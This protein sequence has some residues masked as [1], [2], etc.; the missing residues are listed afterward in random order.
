LR[1]KAEGIDL[2]R[3]ENDR[4]REQ[5]TERQADTQTDE[6][7]VRQKT[8]RQAHKQTHTQ[9]RRESS[10]ACVSKQVRGHMDESWH[11]PIKSKSNEISAVQGWIESVCEGLT[12]G[13]G[14][15]K[16]VIGRGNTCE[17]TSEREGECV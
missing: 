4:E 1:K 13:G 2:E 11:T 14:L 12:R 10:R 9:T 15:T 6:Q 3:K 5:G 8:D 16:S 17:R 7:A